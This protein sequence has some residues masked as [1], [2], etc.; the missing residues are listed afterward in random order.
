MATP[1]VINLIYPIPPSEPAAVGLG[2]L[3]PSDTLIDDQYFYLVN[4]SPL[5]SGSILLCNQYKNYIANTSIDPGFI[6]SK[7]VGNW[8]PGV[9]NAPVFPLPDNPYRCLICQDFLINDY[10]G[11]GP[12]YLPATIT[13]FYAEPQPQ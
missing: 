10:I 1:G 2:R 12:P 6:N 3:S 7:F 4:E 13:V 5:D 9:N 8:V 11:D